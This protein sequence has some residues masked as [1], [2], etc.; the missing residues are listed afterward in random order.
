MLTRATRF[1]RS[2]VHYTMLFT[3]MHVICTASPSRSALGLVGLVISLG[4]GASM[5]FTVAHELVHST[6]DTER[7]LLSAVLLLPNFYM[8]WGRAHVQHHAHVG[9]AKDPTTSRW[10][11]NSTDVPSLFARPDSLT[12]ATRFVRSPAKER[13]CMP[14][15]SGRSWATSATRTRQSGSSGAKDALRRGLRRRL[16]CWSSRTQR[17]VRS[18]RLSYSVRR[19]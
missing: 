18:A 19:W 15:G 12:R 17:T 14:S 7:T 1:A 6:D 2:P 10:V 11:S 16:L 5:S 4:V 3:V 9:T 8:H 13:P